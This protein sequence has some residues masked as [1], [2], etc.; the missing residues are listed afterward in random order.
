MSDLIIII[1]TVLS[2]YVLYLLLI[3]KENV[4]MIFSYLFISIYFILLKFEILEFMPGSFLDKAIWGI[5]NCLIYIFII[6]YIN[7]RNGKTNN[8]SHS[9]K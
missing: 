8:S 5:Y 7:R 4:K 1:Q 9:K 3:Y 2:V 6:Y